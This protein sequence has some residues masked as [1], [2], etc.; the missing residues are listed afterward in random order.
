VSPGALTNPFGAPLDPGPGNSFNASLSLTLQPTDKFQ[1]KFDF[2][3]SYLKRRD[4]NLL[5]YDT[6]I[7][8]ALATYRFSRFLSTR[9]RTDYET[10]SAQLSGQYLFAWEPKPGTALFVG[11]NNSLFNKA[12]NPF[13]FIRENGLER[14]GQTFFIKFSYLFRKTF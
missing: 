10:L 3:K 14:D 12:L 5:A 7:Y 2:T 6:N 4:T 13:T 8:S 11:Y 1:L 9:A